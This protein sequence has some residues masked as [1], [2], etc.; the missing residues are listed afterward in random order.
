MN[1]PNALTKP[2]LIQKIQW[3]ADPVGYMESAAQEHPDLFSAQVL[4]FGD[5]FVFVNDPKGIQEI[6]TNDRRTFAA[7]GK[8][9]N[10]LEPLLGN[11]AIVM[12]DG[13][14]HKRRRQLLMPP[15]HGERMRAY[16]QLIKTL[17]QKVFADL[18]LGQPFAAR[19]AM[20]EISLQVILQAVFGL[21]EGERC[22]QLKHL[23]AALSD[24]FESPLKASF[25]LLPWLQKDLGAWSPWGRFLRQ[26]QQIDQL[27]YAEIAER[28]A[29]PDPGRIDI[30][31][32]LM[33]A[34]DEAGQPMSDQELRDEL[35]TLMLAGHETTATAMAW[36]L[37]W[38]HAL[39]EIRAKLLPELDTAD[40]AVETR[41]PYLNAVCQETLR[42]HP[43]AMLTFPRVVQTPTELLGHPLEPG[44]VVM[45]CIYTLHQREDL[46]PEPKQFRPERFLTH[47]FSPY[48]F[49]PFGG[50]ARRCIGE[51][52][53][54]FEMK[55]VLTEILARYE[56]ELVDNR[57]E[58]PQRRGVTLAPGRGVQ[59]K[60]TGKR[61]Q[62][63][64]PGRDVA[65]NVSTRFG[66]TPG[67][68][69]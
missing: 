5:S 26:R 11:H 17:T 34:Q 29:N 47:Q 27:I 65:C 42:I 3:I 40:D 36:A 46:Y 64:K 24:L 44:M 56:L 21:Y 61:Q 33:S 15:F 52:L 38:I 7:L 43:V 2:P 20:Q 60:I 66:V 18:P 58:K 48:E 37:Y 22:Q 1:L 67:H 35:M 28:R 31:S 39:P 63:V 12:L 49:M 23:L 6:L 4:G 25:L 19:T 8:G 57:L 14:R 68:H 41:L 50:G 16:G 62:Q 45:G 53:A 59:M 9:N 55:L 32:L 69:S 13:D 10:T 54:Q 30:L 51:A